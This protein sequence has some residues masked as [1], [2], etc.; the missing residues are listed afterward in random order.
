[1]RKRLKHAYVFIMKYAEQNLQPQ[2][3]QKHVTGFG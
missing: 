3:A 1:M 2:E